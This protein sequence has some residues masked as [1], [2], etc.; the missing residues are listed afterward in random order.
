MMALIDSDKL[1]EEMKKWY[2]NEE[3]QKVA[4]KDVI[5]MDLFTNLAITTVREQ[6]I[7][8]DVDKV[9]DELRQLKNKEFSYDDNEEELMDGEEIY[10]EGR[11]QGRYEAFLKSIEIVKSGGLKD[12]RE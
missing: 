10:D 2:W 5:P 9:I 3:K 6:P 8:Y 12:K 11:S 4:A 1:I 7:A